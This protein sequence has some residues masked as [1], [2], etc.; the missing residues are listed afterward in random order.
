M[1]KHEVKTLRHL[2]P[3]RTTKYADEVKAK[4][5]QKRDRGEP[6][7]SAKRVKQ[8]FTTIRAVINFARKRGEHPDDSHPRLL[9]IPPFQ[10]VGGGTRQSR[11]GARLCVATDLSRVLKGR[12]PLRPINRPW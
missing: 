9:T 11:E 5:R 12:D 7:G 1:A 4:A 8:R 10:H 2:T 3:A 6:G